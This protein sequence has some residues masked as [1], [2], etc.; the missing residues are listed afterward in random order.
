MMPM[1]KKKSK[2]KIKNKILGIALI[3]M[4][5]FIVPILIIAVFISLISGITDILYVSFD[6]DDKIDM[7]KE[8]AYYDT[9]YEKSR[10]K[11]EVK[12]FFT[13]V[14]EFVDKIFGGGEIA[15]ETDWPVVRTLY[16]K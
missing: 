8:L 16:D 5:P 10:D 3:I 9:D 14:W 15:D 7:K 11:E 4:K 1:N 13:S 2:N 6:N 12:G